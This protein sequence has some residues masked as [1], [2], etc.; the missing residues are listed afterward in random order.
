MEERLIIVTGSNSVRAMRMYRALKDPKR[1]VLLDGRFYRV[2]DL[3]Y[4]R[5]GF[6][7]EFTLAECTPMRKSIDD[8]SPDEWYEAN[9][10]RHPPRRS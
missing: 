8:C 9:R 5:N 7:W 3:W 10:D 6:V 2:V 4:L 1:V